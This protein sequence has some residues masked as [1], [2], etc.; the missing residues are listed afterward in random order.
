MKDH[1]IELYKTNDEY[2]TKK[3]LK[4]KEIYNRK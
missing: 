2:R 4:M 3:L 1:K